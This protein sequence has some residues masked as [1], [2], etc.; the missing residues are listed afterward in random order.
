[1]I[2]QS[3]N[4]LNFKSVIIIIFIQ[5]LLVILEVAVLFIQIICIYTTLR[6][7]IT[8]CNDSPEFLL[9]RKARSI[10]PIILAQR[11]IPKFY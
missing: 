3:I 11:A 7:L 6:S 5:S 4:N 8:Y 9:G 1:M 2:N 10:A